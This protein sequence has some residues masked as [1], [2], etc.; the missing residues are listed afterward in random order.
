MGDQINLQP[1]DPTNSNHIS[2]LVTI[3]Y[4][5]CGPDL[6]ITS[7]FIEFNTRPATGSVQ[8]GRLA[9]KSGQPVGFVLASALPKDPTV[10][11]PETGWVD[12]IAV[13][14]SAQRQGIGSELLSWAEEWLRAQ[15]CTKARLGGSL[16]P[17]A[18]GLPDEL[19]TDAFFRSRGYTGRPG[20][21]IV[22]DVARDLSDYERRG[23]TGPVAAIRPAQPGEENA[24]LEFFYREFPNRWRFKFQE[25]LRMGG[26]ISDW[27]ILW[28]E[29]GID[30][31]A[32]LTFEDS[33]QPLERSYPNRLPRPWGQLGPIGVSADARGKGYGGL[34]LDAGLVRLRDNGVKGCIIDWTG[35]LEFYG[36]FGFKPYR[37]Y[38]MLIKNQL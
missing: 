25:F 11:P 14:P 18:A 31:F 9:M 3:W 32:R 23:A 1:F 12:A 17:F 27:M 38:I 10:S 7:R 6:A 4:A 19:N 36:K 13:P 35:L 24:L 28:T 22:W 33:V 29:R 5:A 16:R 20:G 30:G 8:A 2:A 21:E 15:G 26:R 34:L 37:N